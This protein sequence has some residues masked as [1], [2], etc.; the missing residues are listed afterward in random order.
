MPVT[1][2]AQLCRRILGLEHCD[3]NL[4]LDDEVVE[5][6]W[7]KKISLKRR[8]EQHECAVATV[9]QAQEAVQQV[10]RAKVFV[11]YGYVRCSRNTDTII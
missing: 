3:H 4:Q 7:F 10:G 2:L 8:Q 11:S 9:V 6:I 5:E 1:S